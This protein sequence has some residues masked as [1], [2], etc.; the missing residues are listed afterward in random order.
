MNVILVWVGFMIVIYFVLFVFFAIKYRFKEMEDLITDE[1]K[2]VKVSNSIN[3]NIEFYVIQTEKYEFFENKEVY[4]SQ[5]VKETFCAYGRLYTE[6][7]SK[8]HIFSKIKD[9][10]QEIENL[11]YGIRLNK[12][13]WYISK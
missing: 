11:Q 2:V 8:A 5:H 7:L 13:K 3:P 1:F 10:E 4:L 9:A 6:D 12:S